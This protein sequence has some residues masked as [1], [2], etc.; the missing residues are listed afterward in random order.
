MSTSQ[1]IR[2]F[3]AEAPYTAKTKENYGANLSY[4]A[5][6]WNGRPIQE[7]TPADFIE[8]LE[9]R[10]WGSSQQ[11][12][13]LCSLKALIRHH[14]GEKDDAGN[15]RRIF[16]FSIRRE[17]PDEQRTLTPEEVR[18]LEQS[19]NLRRPAHCRNLT[20]LRVAIDSRLRSSELCG[21]KL[22]ELDFDNGVIVTR[23][24]GGDRK[25]APMGTDETI[26]ILQAW[27]VER[28]GIARPDVEEVFVN[29]EGE[30][31]GEGIS[32]T[33]WRVVCRR[34]AKKAKIPHFSPHATC[35]SF[36]YFAS[37]QGAPDHI[38][39]EAG[40][41]DDINQVK[42][43]TKALRV[44]DIKPWMPSKLL[45][46]EDPVAAGPSGEVEP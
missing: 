35:R 33:H 11:H 29:T 12:N 34:W 20:M 38:I 27:L 24:K 9:T 25:P 21:L 14:Y 46:S 15:K 30:N 18:K 5:E 37:L 23:R 16:D 6:H 8:F 45:K 26:A 22:S 4:F 2:E 43:Y 32:P 42:R 1:L 13:A 41:W 36:A 19:L 44:K 31:R 40:G 17:E 7:V 10:D 28:R 3:L 39:A